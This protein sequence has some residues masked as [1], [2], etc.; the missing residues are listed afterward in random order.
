[1]HSTDILHWRTAQHC[2]VLRNSDIEHYTALHWH[3]HTVLH[4]ALYYTDVLLCTALHCSNC[5]TALM[6]GIDILH[7]TA[8]DY[9]TLTYCSALCTVLHWHTALLCTAMHCSSCHTVLTY[10]TAPCYTTLTC[11]S[12]M[13]TAL[14]CTALLCTA[15]QWLSY[16]TDIPHCTILHYTDILHCI[17]LHCTA[18]CWYTGLH[19]TALTYS[20]HCTILHYNDILYCTGHFTILT[21]CSALHCSDCQTALT[22]ST[23]LYWHTIRL[24]VL[25]AL[26][27][28]TV[29]ALGFSR[30][31]ELIFWVGSFRCLHDAKCFL[32][33]KSRPFLSILI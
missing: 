26:I 31:F 18:S 4:C 30:V 6:Y 12:A 32:L 14:Y 17:V 9:S 19:C 28:H 20:V 5:H 25:Q 24:I 7:C 2:T 21:Y 22:C 10:C 3:W 1:M 15:L 8:P 16:C 11:G 23:A 29:F 13:C 27:G 33:P